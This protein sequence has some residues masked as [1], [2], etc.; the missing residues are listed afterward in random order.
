[1]KRDTVDTKAHPHH[2]KCTNRYTVSTK[3]KFRLLVTAMHQ[4]NCYLLNQ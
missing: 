3:A 1:M 4:L 2:S